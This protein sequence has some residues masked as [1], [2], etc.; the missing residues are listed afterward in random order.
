M[1]LYTKKVKEV[2]SEPKVEVK[3]KG[4][5]KKVATPVKEE[6]EV[7]VDKAEEPLQPA[8]VEQKLE[9]PPLQPIQEEKT[10]L[11]PQIEEEPVKVELPSKVAA[12]KKKE[13]KKVE[14]KIQPTKKATEETP[15][16]WFKKFVSE[17]GH[18]PEVSKKENKDNV[19]EAA[20]NLWNDRVKPRNS[21]SYSSSY[22]TLFNQMFGK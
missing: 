12:P 16:A 13:Q 2:S 18:N 14:K 22:D 21:S 9:A 15:P 7:E 5:P 3:K 17:L 4:R 20:T 19:K 6:Q 11:P 10:E 8:P 1:G